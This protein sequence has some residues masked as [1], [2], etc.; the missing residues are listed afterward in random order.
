M[1]RLMTAP[2]VAEM[3]G[4]H[5]NYVWAEAKAG[6]IPSILIGR[7]RRFMETDINEWLEGLRDA[8]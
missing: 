8:A 1:D 4:V 2:E 5:V 7:N 3:L 6:R